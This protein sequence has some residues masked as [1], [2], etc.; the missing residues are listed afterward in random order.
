MVFTNMKI[1]LR[2]NSPVAT[3]KKFRKIRNMPQ[4]RGY[5]LLFLA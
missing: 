1:V 4:G 2:I 3:F 5:V